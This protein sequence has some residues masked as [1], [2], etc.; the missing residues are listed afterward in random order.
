VT[1]WS[2]IRVGDLGRVVTG[3]TPPSS[4]PECFGH[5]YPFITPTDINDGQRSCA[6][7][8]FL[9][10]IG[11][12]KRIK[13]LEEMARSLYREWFVKFRFPGHKQVKLVDSPLGKIPSSW[14]VVDL[15]DIA[16]IQWGDTST[17]KASYTP[18]GF[19]AYSASGPDGYLEYA[20][21][22]H[23][24]VVLSA[25]GAQCGKSWYA[26]ESWSCIKN[27]IR[28]WGID[29][30]RASTPFLYY[31]TKDTSFWPRRGAAQPFIS[32]GDA[33]QC[34]LVLADASTMKRFTIV[35]NALLEMQRVLGQ[36]SHNLRRTRDLLLP[37][38]LS[39]EIDV[40]RLPLPGA[41]EG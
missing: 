11:L 6:T 7:A 12:T 3:K 15:G 17:T 20:D 32:L 28:F 22:H 29:N 2:E 18:T 10:R 40:S 13:I 39:G 26:K 34:Q 5:E 19:V 4:A 14:R 24:G 41:G 37:R 38:L 31:V 35:A 23:D 9:S 30:T 33:R 1:A 27:T 25:I 21:Y 36:S 16:D 8:R